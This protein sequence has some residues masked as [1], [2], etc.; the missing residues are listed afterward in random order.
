MP[1]F[2]INVRFMS[3]GKTKSFFLFKHALSD[4]LRVAAIALIVLL[5]IF[6][7]RLFGSRDDSENKTILGY[8]KLTETI[9]LEN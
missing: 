4:Y 9:N 3:T 8:S 5:A 7:L 1:D 6:V 2:L